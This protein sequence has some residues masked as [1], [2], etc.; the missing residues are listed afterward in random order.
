MRRWI[1]IVTVFVFTLLTL[2]I[3]SCDEPLGDY[4]LESDES[5]TAPD[6]SFT[7][8]QYF[9]DKADKTSQ[10]AWLFPAKKSN[11]PTLL[12]NPTPYPGIFDLSPDSQWLLQ[13]QKIWAGSCDV[14]LYRR[15]SNC[16]FVP[17][18]KDFLGDKAWK[19]FSKRP[20]IKKDQIPDFHRS[21]ELSEWRNSRYLILKFSGLN[22]LDVT[23]TMKRWV[24]DDWLCAYDLK[25]NELIQLPDLRQKNLK[26][27][28]LLQ[29]EG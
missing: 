20:G 11:H 24:I 28:Y 9:S 22:I 4:K 5:Y 23:S 19:W 8:Q 7:I 1:E 6:H 17:I 29:K 13:T 26:R 14:Y 16:R 2:Q 21:I 18:N 15:E 12:L 27:I 25:K 10:Q 3:A